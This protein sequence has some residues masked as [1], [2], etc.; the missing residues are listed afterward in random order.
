M[1]LKV[2]KKKGLMIPSSN[3]YK[4]LGYEDWEALNDGQV[5]EL[6]EVG[7]VLKPYLEGQLD[8]KQNKKGDK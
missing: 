5:V 6:D 1:A 4:G 2:K 3:S 7:D 8:T